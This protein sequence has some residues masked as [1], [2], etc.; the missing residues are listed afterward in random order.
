LVYASSLFYMFFCLIVCMRNGVT[1]VGDCYGTN[2]S[3][4]LLWYKYPTK[5]S[6]ESERS[7]LLSKGGVFIDKIGC[8]VTNQCTPCIDSDVATSQQTA[9]LGIPLMLASDA[10]A[11]VPE[12]T[13]FYLEMK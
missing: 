1:H 9:Q 13:L 8:R 10:R 6:C 2:I 12:G 4:S 11:K 3:V 7:R 5:A